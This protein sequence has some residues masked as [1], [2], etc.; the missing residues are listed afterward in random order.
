MASGECF[1]Q[2]ESYTFFFGIVPSTD[3][4]VTEAFATSTLKYHAQ[5]RTS[6]RA[7]LAALCESNYQFIIK[8]RAYVCIL[9]YMYRYEVHV[10][11][12]TRGG[13][14]SSRPPVYIAIVCASFP[15]IYDN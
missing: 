10:H 3:Y 11:V 14:K 9:T 8:Y 6:T 5:T 15:V 2:N 12:H 1:A 4:F 7:F 13:R